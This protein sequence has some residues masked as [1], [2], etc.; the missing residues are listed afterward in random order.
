MQIDEH[1]EAK[2]NASDP[3]ETPVAHN[4]VWTGYEAEIK[5]VKT[6][7]F[8]RQSLF[9]QHF[10]YHKKRMKVSEDLEQTFANKT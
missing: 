6:V 5:R 9:R 1:S 10:F 2:E 4:P 8:K 3:T 7:F